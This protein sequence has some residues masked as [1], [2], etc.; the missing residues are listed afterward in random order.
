LGIEEPGVDEAL[1]DSLL[2]REGLLAHESSNMSRSL[3]DGLRYCLLCRNGR[4]MNVHVIRSFRF[5]S[6]SRRNRRMSPYL[7][8]VPLPR[9]QS[10]PHSALGVDT[11]RGRKVVFPL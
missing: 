11:R 3:V 6:S 4:V 10:K 1:G 5:G 2:S 7:F 9:L 8:R